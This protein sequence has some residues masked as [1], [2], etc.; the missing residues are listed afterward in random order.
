MHRFAVPNALSAG[1][2]GSLGI[3]ANTYTAVTRY[4][5]PGNGGYYEGRTVAHLEA[6]K[7]IEPMLEDDWYRRS[8]R[9]LIDDLRK[10]VDANEAE[11]TS[12]QD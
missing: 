5:A 12:G 1:T 9:T 11:E 7:E 4:S 6:L 8:L 3:A 10:E 2:A